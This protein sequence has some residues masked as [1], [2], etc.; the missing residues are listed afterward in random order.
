MMLT[1]FAQSESELKKRKISKQ[2]ETI[3]LQKAQIAYL[4]QLETNYRLSKEMDTIKNQ[5]A[6]AEKSLK[7]REYEIHN[8]DVEVLSKEAEL[9]A[10][11]LKLHA[12]DAKLQSKDVELRAKAE[13]LRAKDEQIHVLKEAAHNAVKV[14]KESSEY[15]TLMGQWFLKGYD[16]FRSQASSLP[17]YA[18]WPTLEPFS[19]GDRK[20]T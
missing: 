5:L 20:P 15:E 4:D 16:A 8:K 3:A 13:E 17:P 18:D 7:T 19:G 2:E 10:K 14:F 12:K 9:N 6:E 1:F 11:D